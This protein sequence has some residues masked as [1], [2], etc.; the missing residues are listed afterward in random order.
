MN[1]KYT[2]VVLTGA[3]S[4]IGEVMVERLIP[5]CQDLVLVARRGELL[6]KIAAKAIGCRVH[7]VAADVSDTSAYKEKLAQV[8]EPLPACQLVLLNAGMGHQHRITKEQT[9]VFLQTYGVN[10]FGAIATLDVTLPAMLAANRGHIVGIASLAA[11]RG[12]ATMAAYTSS[13]SAL[14]RALESFRC[15][16][17][18]TDISVTTIHPG[19]VETPMSA[20]N[21]GKM[22]FLMDCPTAVNKIMKAIAAK[23]ARYTFPWQ[24]RLIFFFLRMVPDGIYARCYGLVGGRALVDPKRVRARK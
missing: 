22:P 10:L 21:K 18:R 17:A 8:L 11:Y 7:V 14:W 2:T 20:E 15:E 24:F 23:K 1:K 16:L 13:K 9:E 4:G 6:E 3:S 12:M 5:L 19:F